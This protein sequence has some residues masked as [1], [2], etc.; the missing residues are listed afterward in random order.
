M[1]E[2]LRE[3]IFTNFQ[4][5][6]K[7]KIFSFIKNFQY[8]TDSMTPSSDNSLRS[9][10]EFVSAHSRSNLLIFFLIFSIFRVFPRFRRLSFLKIFS[11]SGSSG[12]IWPFSWI[13]RARQNAV[14]SV[15]E[16][17]HFES[18]VDRAFRERF[19]FS[20][21]IWRMKILKKNL[22][23]RFFPFWFSKANLFASKQ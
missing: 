8:R 19:W 11:S 3:N 20:R 22:V 17:A 10:S 5:F 23:W 13:S 4:I 1:N 18:G 7:S 12:K 16:S 15:A 21:G 2:Y 6:K 14:W 9:I